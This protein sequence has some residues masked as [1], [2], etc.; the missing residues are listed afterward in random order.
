MMKINLIIVLC[1]FLAPQF[2]VAQVY[3]GIVI[4]KDTEIP[5]ANANVF[6]AGTLTGTTTNINGRFE[7]NTNG[8]ISVPVVFSFVGYTTRVFSFYE[9]SSDS[10]IKLE[11]E[12]RKIEEINVKSN[13]GGWSR[14]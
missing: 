11:K 6:L 14:G 8:N 5:M 1:F 7:L 10:I 2:L 12:V 4:D 13:R 9:L 3:S